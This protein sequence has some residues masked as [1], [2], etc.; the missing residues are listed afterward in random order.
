[1]IDSRYD[2]EWLSQ[3]AELEGGVTAPR[4]ISRRLRESTVRLRGL[5]SCALLVAL[6]AALVWT[7]KLAVGL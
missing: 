4:R 1:M 6:V 3:K 7:L 5:H 2:A